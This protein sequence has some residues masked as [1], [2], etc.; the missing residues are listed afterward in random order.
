[1]RVLV[2]TVV[3]TPLDARI[4]R[5]QAGALL[6]AGHQVVLAAP[7]RGHGV[8]ED[9]VDARIETVDLPRAAARRRVG[10]L[11]AAARL[12][13]ERADHVDVVVLHDPELLLATV[14]LTGRVPVVWDV[15]EDLAGS[16][17]DKAWVPRPVRG[18][19][20]RGVR[21]LEGWAERRVAV[22]LAEEGYR[23]RFRGSHPV[24]PNLPPLPGPPRGPEDDR[25]VYVG[26][27]SRLRGAL[28]LVAVSR[29]LH[30][31]GILL[32]VIG[33]VDDDVAE[34]LEAAAASGL[35]EL[36]GFVPNV[37][38]ME[39]LDGA[40]AGLSL[41]HD[42][43]NY[44]H[45]L[46]TKVAEYQASGVPV[47]TTPLPAAVA[48]V[49]SGGS[50]VVVPF[51]DAD[52]VADA[53]LSLATDRDRARELSRAGRRAAEEGASWDAVAPAFVRAIESVV[54]RARTP[55]TPRRRR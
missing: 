28:E 51:G 31:A 35:L 46:P 54:S 53:V 45:S 40:L 7:F 36:A 49:E 22:L 1:M 16:L 5:R 47:V 27:V 25:V 14:G 6:D 24:V 3:H 43:P 15:H 34:P 38:A 2:C 4:H 13:R 55:G 12:L 17:D 23:A 52:A 19:L 50:G 18:M 8:P 37:R 21:A 44:R 20:R 41:L 33:P 39:R 29:P 42:H 10:S 9:A 11:A 32:E 30:E 48:M 26:R